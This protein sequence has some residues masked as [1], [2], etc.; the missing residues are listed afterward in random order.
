MLGHEPQTLSG[1]TRS[2]AVAKRAGF[3]LAVF[4]LAA[5]LQSLAG[6]GFAPTLASL[7]LLTGILAA[8][9]GIMC[10]DRP[11][12]LHFTYFDE[13]AWFMLIG[14]VVRRMV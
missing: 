7:C 11:S 5:G 2:L 4:V 1:A 10:R 13:A 9:L 12:S 6:Y 3:K 8:I 14:H